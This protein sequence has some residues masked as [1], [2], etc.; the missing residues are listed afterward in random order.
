MSTENI[1]IEQAEALLNESF[2]KLQNQEPKPATQVVEPTPAPSP[3]PEPTPTPEIMPAE[4]ATP[5]EPA[6]GVTPPPAVETSTPSTPSP[7]NPYA[8]VDALPDDI[9]QKVIGEINERFKHEHQARS[10]AGRVKALQR[11]LLE[12]EKNAAQRKPATEPAPAERQPSTPESW[13]SLAKGDPELAEAIE[14]RVKSD[15]DAAVSSIKNEIQERMKQDVAPLHEQRVIAYR[16]AQFNELKKM[17]PNVED[18][19][20]SREYAAWLQNDATD[21]LRHIA[22]TSMDARDALFV[23]QAYAND[24]H[25]MGLDK[26]PVAPPAPAAHT[27]ADDIAAARQQQLQTQTP[28]PAVQVAPVGTGKTANGPMTKEDAEAYFAQVVAKYKKT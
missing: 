12:Q 16:E 4:P 14:A 23:L 6:E 28:K 24:M 8:W 3:T 21:N 1:T 25:R 5:V 13:Q 10:D 17:V 20:G 22:A 19:I 15:I 26:P 18:V 11:K 2:A 9:K 27:K 7:D